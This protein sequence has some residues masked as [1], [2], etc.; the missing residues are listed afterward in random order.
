VLLSFKRGADEPLYL[1]KMK[2]NTAK[3]KKKKNKEFP[4]KKNRKCKTS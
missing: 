3:E 4:Y 1:F 2:R